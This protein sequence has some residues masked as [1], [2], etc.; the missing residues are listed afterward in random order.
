[1]AQRRQRAGQEVLL[2]ELLQLVTHASGLVTAP[3]FSPQQIHAPGVKHVFRRPGGDTHLCLASGFR[4][5]G[6][7]VT[8]HR[9]GVN[10]PPP[11][12]V[13]T[14]AL[15]R[16]P[17]LPLVGSEGLKGPDAPAGAKNRHQVP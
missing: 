1:M 4:G 13:P 12:R 7:T 10:P 8:R 17:K 6:V 15:D 2:S 16:G 9:K 14:N 3:N 5:S 11:Y